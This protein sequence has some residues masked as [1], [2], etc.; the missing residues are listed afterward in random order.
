MIVKS[1]TVMLHWCILPFVIKSYQCSGLSPVTQIPYWSD[2]NSCV[3]I[4]PG[5]PSLQYPRREINPNNVYWNSTQSI[6]RRIS[7]FPDLAASF[8]RQFA[9]RCFY[10]LER[11]LENLDKVINGLTKLPTFNVSKVSQLYNLILLNILFW[12]PMT[13]S[14]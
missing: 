1:A 8:L 2:R 13:W 6:H 12:S 10:N 9:L 3:D 5:L 11:I 14:V 7:S 4:L